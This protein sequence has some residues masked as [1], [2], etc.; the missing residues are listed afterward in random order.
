MMHFRDL[1]ELSRRVGDTTQKKEKTSF[2]AECVKRGQGQEIA[3]AASIANFNY[4]GF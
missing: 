2:L 3:L 4:R 1:V